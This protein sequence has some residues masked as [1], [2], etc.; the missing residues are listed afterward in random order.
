MIKVKFLD[1][2]GEI[3]SE[4]QK[5]VGTR[6]LGTHFETDVHKRKQENIVQFKNY[7]ATK[8]ATK[9]FLGITKVVS[10]CCEVVPK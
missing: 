3:L 1:V 2:N 4:N 5:S 9:R 8:M 6:L 10:K 7:V